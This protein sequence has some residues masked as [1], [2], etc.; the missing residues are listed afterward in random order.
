MGFCDPW[1]AIRAHFLIHS[2]LNHVTPSI[3]MALIVY[4]FTCMYFFGQKVLAS[5]LSLVP[6]K[7]ALEHAAINYRVSRLSLA[8][9]H[10][11]H[12]IIELRIE[13]RRQAVGFFRLENKVAPILILF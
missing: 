5:A 8:L 3:Y 9:S 4:T 12:V 13:A 1:V 7:R 2:V 10:W 11:C 6:V